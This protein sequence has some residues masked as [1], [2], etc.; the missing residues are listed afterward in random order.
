M[1]LHR[2]YIHGARFRILS[3]SGKAPAAQEQAQGYGAIEIIISEVLVKFDH[4][5]EGT[6]LYGALSSVRT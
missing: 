4:D 5:A 1:M 2:F 3:K 6:C